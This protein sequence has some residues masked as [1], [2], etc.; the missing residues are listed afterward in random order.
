MN[1]SGLNDGGDDGENRDDLDGS[2]ATKFVVDP[3]D[4]Q[5]S[6]ESAGVVD[7]DGSSMIE[8]PYGDVG[9][10]S[11]LRSANVISLLEI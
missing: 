9:S 8:A 5:T 4:G 2:T 1:R 10:I 3:V 7:A 11:V 6:Q